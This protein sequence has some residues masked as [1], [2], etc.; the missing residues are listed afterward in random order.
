M[1]GLE[2]TPERKQNVL[3]CRPY[4]IYKLQ[5]IS[6]D[7]EE[8]FTNLEE[9]KGKD[10]VVGTLAATAAEEMLDDWKIGK[11][12]YDDQEGPF[13]DL[14]LKRI[15]GVFFDLPIAIYYAKSDEKNPHAKK[16]KG[17]K[18]AG[19]PVGKG[20]YG[21]AVRKDKRKSLWARSTMGWIGCSRAANCE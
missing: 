1:N 11:K 9:C 7:G 15:D 2:I 21:I 4:Y 17:V 18:I 13:K 20:Y 8:R 6:R 19:E 16:I 3:F 12:I 14:L 10:V 5:L